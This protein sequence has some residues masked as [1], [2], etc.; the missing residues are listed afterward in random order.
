LIIVLLLGLMLVGCASSDSMTGDTTAEESET[1]GV[2]VN[3]IP[4]LAVN[5]FAGNIRIRTGEDGRITANL[6]K[7]SRLPDE[8]N[9]QA[10][11]D[12]IVMAFSQS[13]PDVTLNI[14]GPATAAGTADSATADLDLLVSP[15]TIL[16][17]NLGT[18]DVTVEQPGGDLT[19]DIG[20]G[21]ATTLV[22]AGDS[23]RLV[24]TGGAVDVVSEFEGVPG[25][26]E[27]VNIDTTIGDNPAQTFS[28][29]VGAGEVRLVEA[30]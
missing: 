27:A 16:T 10:E 22:P 26:G 24:V 21:N 15:G 12:N 28:Y 9:A 1:Q 23:F 17:V 20:A 25:G 4:R 6:T 18:G 30:Q 14:E 5:H 11:L 2:I 13:G 7:M 19:V 3:G 8:A 29:N